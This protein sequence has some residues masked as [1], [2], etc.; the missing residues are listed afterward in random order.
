M[1][2]DNPDSIVATNPYPLE[3]GSGNNSCASLEGMQEYWLDNIIIGFVV[4]RVGGLEPGET[5][6]VSMYIGQT[7]NGGVAVDF[8]PP[9]NSPAS[10][11]AKPFHTVKTG[12]KSSQYVGTYFLQYQ[13]QTPIGFVR[14][15]KADDGDFT[16][17][18]LT[19]GSIV[20]P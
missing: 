10:S 20:G 7:W 1:F 2:T 13:S 3:S 14:I 6:Y 19:F 15:R 17:D 12:G 11:D 18:D 8:Y 9:G 16:I 4:P 5:R